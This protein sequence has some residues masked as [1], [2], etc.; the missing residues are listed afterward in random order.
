MRRPKLTIILFLFVLSFVS[1]NCEHCDDEDYTREKQEN[2]NIKKT[3]TLT[4]K[5]ALKVT[6]IPKILISIT[7]LTFINFTSFFA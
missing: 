2:L 1:L 4:L 7:Y 6:A 5:I 3:D